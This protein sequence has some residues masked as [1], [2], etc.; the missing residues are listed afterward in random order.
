MTISLVN[1][2]TGEFLLSK[3]IIDV[4]KDFSYAVLK[5]WK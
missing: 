4:C 2:S 5:K 1:P 3:K